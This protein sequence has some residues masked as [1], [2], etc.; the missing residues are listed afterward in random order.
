MTFKNDGQQQWVAVVGPSGP[1]VGDGSAVDFCATLVP[2]GVLWLLMLVDPTDP[3][4]CWAAPG[5]ATGQTGK[6]L[7]WSSAGLSML[8]GVQKTCLCL[9]P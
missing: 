3:R 4:H 7:P 2:C 6:V 5:H 9:G 1:S 8:F